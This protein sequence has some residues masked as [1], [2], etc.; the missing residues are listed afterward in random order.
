MDVQKGG[1]LILMDKEIVLN[2]RCFKIDKTN[3]KAMIS[4]FTKDNALIHQAIYCDVVKKPFPMLITLNRRPTKF[5]MS[6]IGLGLEPESFSIPYK[7]VAFLEEEYF[8]KN[9]MALWEELCKNG[10]FDV[11]VPDAPYKR[12][13]ECHS[14]PSKFRIVLLRIYEIDEQ[15]SQ[16][17][18]NSVS[19]RVD[20]IST[21]DLTV[22]LKK[23]VIDD[24]EFVGIKHILESSIESSLRRPLKRETII[25]G[26]VESRKCERCG[27]HEIGIITE[28]G[29]YL[30]L[31][32]GMKVELIK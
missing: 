29:Q 6:K 10:L 4:G 25:K 2:K 16:D 5:E 30:P 27:H 11:W 12:F 24:G 8:I 31:K 17:E 20:H 3:A 21:H 14:D 1:Q 13:Q 28:K 15:F 32:P 23:P 22:T 26:I 18:I 19:D 7:Y 9:E